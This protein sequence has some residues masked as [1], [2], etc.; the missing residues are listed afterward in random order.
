[1]TVADEIAT[2]TERIVQRFDPL[3]VILFG[4][5]ARGDAGPHSDVDLLVVMSACGDRWRAAGEIKDQLQDVGVATDVIV[6]SPEEIRQRGNL[7]G[8]VLRP[9]LREGRVLYQRNQD[10]HLP[11]AEPVSE[12]DAIKEAEVWLVFA[13]EDMA[14][15]E[16]LLGNFGRSPRHAG[17]YAQQAAEKALKAIYIY[18]QIQ[19]P[20]V[21]E[22]DKLRDGLPDD[23]P[24]KREFPDLG[25]LNTWA[26]IQRYPGAA[27]LLSR[28]DARRH[29]AMVRALLTAVRRDLAQHGFTA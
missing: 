7:V 26:V 4:S 10:A 3:A 5:Q 11:K 14:A 12:A 21:P 27:G 1:M 25:A 17:F 19:Y 18:L 29:V 22:L 15:A 23:W 24:L 8:T 2:M 9:A 6:T 20:L 16:D 28:D 13:D